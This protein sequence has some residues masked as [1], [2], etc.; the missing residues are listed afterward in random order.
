MKA[1]DAEGRTLLC[2]CLAAVSMADGD[3]DGREIAT[4]VTMV[5]QVTG[6]AITADEV[7]AVT[8]EDWDEFQVELAVL[9]QAAT[10]EFRL[11]ILKTSILVGRADDTMIDAEVERIYLL[12]QA[13]GFSRFEVDEQF[14]VIR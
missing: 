7:V 1:N 5:E 2:R 13:L 3:L 6:S 10:T 8:S 4:I 12:A 14:K 9:V 11:Q